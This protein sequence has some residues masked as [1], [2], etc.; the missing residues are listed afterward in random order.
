MPIKAL[1]FDFGGVIVRT[2][3]WSGRARWD[4]HLGLP[5]DSVYQTV[6]RSE[7]ARRATLGEVPASQVWNYVGTT[8]KLDDARL[9][10][11]RDD[12]FAGDRPDVR[13]IEFI[14]KLRPRYK[15]AVLSNAWS[16]AREIFARV[17]GLQD[18]VDMLIISSE[19]GLAKPD[20]R[21]YQLAAG[22]LGVL[23]EEAI[24]VDDVADN[25][26]AARQA[27]MQAIQ[28]E[29]TD[30]VIAQIQQYLL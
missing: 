28:F 17:T 3:D 1:L 15:T 2:E 14:S 5:E 18:A 22:R 26:V 21:I 27:G 19:A 24:F 20:P 29:N 4:R 6:F 25:V 16:D 12:F 11:F 9:R 23:P 13:L 10:Q 7:I 8:L 30:Q